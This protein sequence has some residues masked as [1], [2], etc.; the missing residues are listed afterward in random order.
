M[1]KI[2][3]YLLV[4]VLAV[5]LWSCD[6]STEGLTGITYYPIIELMGDASMSIPLGTPYEEPGLT[7]MEGDVDVTDN[8]NISGTVD[9]NTVGIYTLTYS[10]ANVDGFSSSVSR[11]VFVY[12][13]AVTTD[14]SGTYT[15]AEG[16]YRLVLA[17]NYTEE[18]LAGMTVIEYEGQQWAQSAFSGYTVTLTQMAPGL[19]AM[20]DYLGGYYDQGVDYGSAYAMTG[21]LQL[22]ADNTLDI[23]SGDVAGW[24][25][26]YESFADA[27]CDPDAGSISY[28]LG[29]AGMLFNIVLTK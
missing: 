10:V 7:A 3:A 26:S 8:V 28:M 22:H 1:K 2:L 5:A 19:L 17:S 20:S 11:T 4:P 25:D 14:I 9:H 12:D 15:T 27:M 16:S 21:Y 6:K 23:I 18:Q 24:G 13:P 29:Y